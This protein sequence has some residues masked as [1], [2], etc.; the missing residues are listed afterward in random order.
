MGKEA[1]HIF[2]SLTFDDEGDKK[3]HSKVMRK[4][5]EY[6]VPKKNVIHERARFRE[7]KQGTGESSE[8]FIRALY[9]LAEHCDFNDKID[10]IR[11]QIVIGLKDKE[12]SEK[13]QLKSTLTLEEAIQYSRQTEMV[14]TQIQDQTTHFKGLDEVKRY[15]KQKQSS[16]KHFIAKQAHSH[17]KPSV[18]QC[19][20]C[21]RK[22]G[23]EGRCPAMG[24][25]CKGC[26]K[27]NHFEVCCRTKNTKSAHSVLHAYD[28]NNGTPD[29][30]FHLGS[31]NCDQTDDPW[32]VTL[33]V[34]DL[35]VNFKI[36]T[37]AD[38]TIMSDVTFNGILCQP[39][40]TPVKS[41]L[42]SPG[43]KLNRRGKF[44][45]TLKFKEIDYTFSISVVEGPQTSNLLAR[46]VANKLKLIYRVDEASVFGSCGLV[47]CTPM[48]ITL[49]EEVKPYCLST[50]R[51][52]PFPL[53][54]K[55]EEELLRMEEEGIIQKVTEPT[56]WCAPMVPVVK[57]NGKIRICVDLKKL[58]EAVIR[59]NFMLPNLDDVSPKLVGAKYFSK[60][61]ASSGFYQVPLHEDSWKLTTFITQLSRF[62]FKRVPFGITSASEIFQ[63]EMSTLLHGLEGTEVIMDDILI[64]GKTREEHDTRLKKTLDR[65]I[66]SG[67]KLNKKKV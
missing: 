6:F 7:R 48:N 27:M 23:P 5:D 17:R 50:A 44:V 62:C 2:K 41:L 36:D 49:K 51:R 39:Q 57:K 59:G 47:K 60:L 37:G 29:E 22:H 1:E 63:R 42:L 3:K 55:V 33:K 46:S 45:A 13:L 19:G 67:L 20:R 32:T 11:D 26:H 58:N 16:P 65:I 35:P 66:E 52:V 54:P 9:E 56:E 31:V 34:C 8:P 18:Q 28:S 21:N 61:D 40:L 38:I 14:K 53:L 43:G 30:T 4:Y 10:Q 24:Q 25:R 15:G 64:Y 12:V